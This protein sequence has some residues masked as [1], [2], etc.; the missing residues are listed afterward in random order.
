MRVVFVC[1]AVDTHDFI[2]AGSVRWIRA[3]S[4]NRKVEHV[5]VITLRQGDVSL[6]GNVTVHSI[7]RNSRLATLLRFYRETFAALTRGSDCF[8]I[9]QGGPY[10]ALLLPLK[11]FLKKP[12]LQWKAHPHIGRS[13]RLYARF[14]N[15]KVFTS[16]RNAFPLDLPSVKIVGQGI[17]TKQ[18]RMTSSEKTGDLVTVG[19]ISPIKRID[20]MIRMIADCPLEYGRSYRLDIYGPIFDKDVKY[21]R[22]LNDQI[23]A[24]GLQD[25]VVFRG[26]VV[27]NQLPGILNR[28]CAFVFFC[29]SAL[30]RAAVEAMACGL[31]VI[32]TNPCVEEILPEGLKATLMVPKDQT[33]AQSR[34]VVQLLS[35]DRSELDK[36]GMI[37]RDEVVRHHNIEGLVDRILT[38]IEPCL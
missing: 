21:K 16:T 36:I 33:G 25:L 5:Y 13:L 26:P 24:L 17:D 22:C 19:R 30:G 4:E 34:K 7:G 8:F 3:F 2:S 28:Y 29:E 38:E 11:W 14:C 18:F 20:E 6:P 12:I 23:R 15:T 9:Y 35:L 32:S 1:Q 10:P 31:P 27:Q 37:L